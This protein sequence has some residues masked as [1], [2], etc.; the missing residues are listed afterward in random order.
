MAI[1]AD[2]MVLV[3]TTESTYATDA[4][5]AGSDAV[6]A[7]N[8]DVTPLQIESQ[9]RGFVRPH[10]GRSRQ[11]HYNERVQLQFS[12]ELAGSGTKDTAPAWGR[13]L[14][15]CGFSETVTASTDVQ[16]DPVSTGFDSLTIYAF[17][18]D[19]KHV[20][21]G[22]RGSVSLT[23]DPNDGAPMLTF[24]F[25]GLYADPSK[26]S[27]PTPDWSAWKYG[28]PV[29]SGNQTFTF[30]GTAHPLVSLSLDL[31]VAANYRPI[32]N[33]ESVD[34]VDRDPT[35]QLVIDAP[36][37]GSDDFWTKAKDDTLGDMQVTHGASDGEI[38]EISCPAA[39]ASNPGGVQITDVD[40]G[41]NDGIATLEMGLALVPSDTGDDEIKIT[42]K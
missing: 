9:Q 18:G 25:T 34:I 24:T 40:Y 31:G 23:Y 15:G 27:A 1:I 22:A 2:K 5:P 6:L 29:K 35:G 19:Q 7:F 26:T 36:D 3:G 42:T 12:V 11:I 16:Y 33:G 39:S 4:S 17:K 38:V 20:L 21:L 8:V 30:F 37:V 13:F 32:I 10:L 28:L 41:E 14:K